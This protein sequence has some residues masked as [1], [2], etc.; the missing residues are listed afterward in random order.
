M[1]VYTVYGLMSVRVATEVEAD[2]VYQAATTATERSVGSDGDE[3]TVWVAT[4]LTQPEPYAVVASNGQRWDVELDDDDA[5]T[6]H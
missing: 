2:H 3:S 6:V 1:P 4:E 5:G